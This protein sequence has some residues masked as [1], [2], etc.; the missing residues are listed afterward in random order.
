[1][2]EFVIYL[3]EFRC[4]ATVPAYLSENIKEPE[5]QFIHDNRSC[6]PANLLYV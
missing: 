6:L 5:I 3:P 4:V 1:V 2:R